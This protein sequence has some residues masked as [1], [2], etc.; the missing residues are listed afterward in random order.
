M[1]HTRVWEEEAPTGTEAAS[2]GD[3]RIRNLK[4]D[5]GERFEDILYGFDVSSGTGDEATV[6]IKKLN[7]KEQSSIAT[8][9]ANQIVIAAKEADSKA[10]LFFVDEDGNERQWTSGGKLK[11]IAGDYA[12]NSIDEDDIRLANNA[13]LTARNA[14]GTGDI[15]LAKVNAS[16]V[17]EIPVGAV[18]SAD[19]APASDPAIA[20]KKYVDD[21]IGSANWTPT[22]YAGE[23]SVT[24]PNGLILKQGNTNKADTTTPILFAEAFPTACTRVTVSGVDDAST[25]TY[26]PVIDGVSKTGFDVITGSPIDSYNWIAIGY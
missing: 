2:L 23:E 20:N 11:V 8:P 21:N 12:A 18:L 9:L 7:F 17:T 24:F 16:D 1:A 3:D 22:S 13:Y 25:D 14:A 6:G 15:N 26:V 19:T 10:E 4:V 5:I